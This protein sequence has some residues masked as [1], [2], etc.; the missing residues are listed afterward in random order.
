MVKFFCILTNRKSIKDICD[1]CLKIYRAN[2]ESSPNKELLA[3]S[4]NITVFIFKNGML[5]LV[6]TA[7]LVLVKPRISYVRNGILDPILPTHF[8][9][10]NE[11]G[12]TGYTILS[13][14]HMYIVF[15]FVIGT[16]GCDLFL[17]TLV[18]HCYTMSQIFLNFVNE[19]NAL[20]QTPKRNKSNADVCIFLENLILMHNDFI[21]LP[22]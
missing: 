19:F 13:L 20:I 7:T 10:I 15:V 3:K 12:V 17:M 11:G 9:G 2:T 21:K 4:V 8:P 5:L 6:T 14:Y 18:V 22:K 1:F 16:A